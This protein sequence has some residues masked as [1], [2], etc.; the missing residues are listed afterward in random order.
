MCQKMVQVCQIVYIYIFFK[1]KN[2]VWLDIFLIYGY[3]FRGAV[4]RRKGDYNTAI[5]DFLL[6]LDK[7]QHDAGRPTFNTAQHQLLL[8]YNDFA[9]ECCRKGFF[10][11]AITLLGKA[12]NCNRLQKGLYLN[13]GGKLT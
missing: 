12:I 10:D 11:E 13:R 9:L 4:Y 7:T 6:A 5:D 1:K 3:C 8:T 2:L